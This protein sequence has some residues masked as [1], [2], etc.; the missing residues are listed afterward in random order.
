MKKTFFPEKGLAIAL[1]FLLVSISIVQIGSSSSGKIRQELSVATKEK[2]KS[3]DTVPDIVEIGDLMLLDLRLDQ[4]NEWRRPGMCNEHSAIY[5]GNNTL[6]EAN[7]I[8]RYRNF[9]QFSLWAKD[10]VF[11]RVKTASESQR[12]AAV[13]WAI[14]KIG[15]PFQIFFDFP[16]YGLKIANTNLRFPTANEIYCFEL[17]W[18]AYYTQGIDIDRNG[19]RF[20][21]WVTGNDILY[22]DDV[23]I[24][25]RSVANSTEITKPDKG[26]YVVN[27]KITF[28]TFF[29]IVIGNIDVEVSTENDN[30]TKV[31]FYI[32][33]VYKATDNTR[34]YTWSWNERGSGKKVI[35]AV[36]CDNE[37]NQ[38]Y[39]KITMW[40]FF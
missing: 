18:G 10:F 37:G 32:D 21:Q 38:Y 8:V 30:V 15:A 4:S 36:A 23:E 13:A 24:I 39:S 29:T 17:L 1:I 31:D 19:W 20:P 2:N 27:R 3:F 16:W 35:K 25:Y 11:L 22:D 26:L 34:P 14:S 5:I 6:V 33:D 28:T 9:T 7:G 12:K 40:R